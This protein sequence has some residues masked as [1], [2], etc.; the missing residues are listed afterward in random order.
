MSLLCHKYCWGRLLSAVFMKQ[1]RGPINC[2]LTGKPT[3]FDRQ[4][5]C[6]FLSG[7]R[8]HL[9]GGTCP[10]CPLWVR[11]C[12]SEMVFSNNVVI[13]RRRSKRIPFLESVNYSTYDTDETLA[14]S[15]NILLVEFSQRFCRFHHITIKARHMCSTKLL[16]QYVCNI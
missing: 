11:H 9:V 10:F 8:G 7:P 2:N 14:V 1:G 16:R 6:S 12:C 15:F 5:Q 4:I 3:T 13:F